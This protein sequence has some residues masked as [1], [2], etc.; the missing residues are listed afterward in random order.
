MSDNISVHDIF[1]EPCYRIVPSRFPPIG[2]FERVSNPADLD[3]VF[4]LEALTNDRLRDETGDLSLVM[5]EDRISGPNTSPIM[6]AF[7]H[8]NPDGSRF[9][10]G[11]YGV[12]YAANDLETAII[13]VKHHR[14]NFMR[15]TNEPKMELDMRAYAITVDAALHDIRGLQNLR[16]DLYDP[17]SY[18]TSQPFAKR[19]REEGS[20]GIVYDSVR[21]PE[22]ECIA[23]FKPRAISNCRQANHLY[24]LWDGDRIAQVYEKKILNG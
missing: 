8:V 1:W 24:F 5:P 23:A 17:E 9:T 10:D 16:S 18:A 21:N 2:L 14:E 13:E 20:W 12:F 15:A 22:G 11:M 4:A 3:A 19:L 6:A 7:T